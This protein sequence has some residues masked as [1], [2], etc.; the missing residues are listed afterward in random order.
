MS[1]K[2]PKFYN[3]LRARGQIEVV[4][5]NHT[6]TQLRVMFR[7]PNQSTKTWMAVVKGLLQTAKREGWSL[8]LSKQFF[9]VASDSDDMRF[10]HRLILQNADLEKVDSLFSDVTASVKVAATQL[11]EVPLVGSPNRSRTAG[12]M[13]QV[14]VGM[15]GGGHRG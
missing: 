7:V 10:G 1:N 15:L 12:P 2:L 9:L 6:S 3:A 4:S 13:G 8:D 5:E 14:R 11:M